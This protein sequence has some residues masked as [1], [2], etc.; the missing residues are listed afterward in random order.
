MLSKAC[1]AERESGRHDDH[2]GPSSDTG[3]GGEIGR[4]FSSRRAIGIGH[5]IQQEDET[6][7]LIGGKAQG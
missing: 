4:T 3:S 2:R 7:D 5:F 6:P 1:D